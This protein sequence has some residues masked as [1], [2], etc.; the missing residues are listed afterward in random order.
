MQAV[1]CSPSRSRGPSGTQRSLAAR[2]AL[3]RAR[4]RRRNA[5]AVLFIVS[6]TL[7]LLAVMG[8]YGLTATAADIRGA[9]SMREAVQAQRAGEAALMMTAETFNPTVAQGLV[10]TMN[11]GGA[12]TKDCLTAAPYT[13]NTATRAAESCLR[14]DPARMVVIANTSNAANPFAWVVAGAPAEPGFTA[15]SFGKVA[16]QPRI[17]V[18]VANPINIEVP[19]GNSQNVQYTQ[20]TATVFV[21]IRPILGGNTVSAVA[22]RARL[23]VGPSLVNGG[24]PSNLQ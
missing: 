8:V 23:T 21:Q 13:G 22:G 7:G 3:A 15:Q 2:R 11:L 24:P 18:E 6:V 14:L 12:Q 9:G 19:A 4:A 17:N 20:V 10:S 5:G 1:A 16:N